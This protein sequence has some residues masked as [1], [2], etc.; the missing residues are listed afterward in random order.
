MIVW[1]CRHLP[2]WW[3]RLPRLPWVT[4]FERQL[5]A[6]F[7]VLFLGLMLILPV[8]TIIRFIERRF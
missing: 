5:A 4:D 8:M 7:V 6:V 1:G 3:Y 2:G